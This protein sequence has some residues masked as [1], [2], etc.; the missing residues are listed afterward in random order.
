MNDVAHTAPSSEKRPQILAA[1]RRVF[2]REH[3]ACASMESIAQEAGVSKQTVY[4]HFGCKEKLF[5]ELVREST[6]RLSLTFEL[7]MTDL[8]ASPE[9]V[10][11]RIGQQILDIMLNEETM[12]LHRL[13]HSEGRRSPQT[14]NEFYSFGPN[15]IV[16]IIAEYLRIQVRARRLELDNPRIASE[17]FTTMLIGHLR[18][19][20]LL[21]IGPSPGADERRRY[22]KSAVRIFLDGARPRK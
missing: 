10:L 16:T 14:A 15:R 11:T 13:M 5:R 22:V 21:G 17:Q 1:A 6:R 9:A 18:L 20:R 3:Y 4:N 8:E 12:E 19:R 2:L 7:D